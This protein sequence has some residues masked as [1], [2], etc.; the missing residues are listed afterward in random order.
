MDNMSDMDDDNLDTSWIQTETQLQNLQH[1][2][3]REPMENIHAVFLYINQNNYIDKIVRELIQLTPDGNSGSH[4]TPEML[5]KIIQTKKYC[6][7]VSKYK[8]TNMYTYIVDIEPDKIQSFSKTNHDELTNTMF[9]KE[10]PITGTIHVP[11][12]VF[13]FHSI[14]TVYFFFQELLVEKNDQPLKSILKPTRK[15][16]K[17]EPDNKPSGKHTKKVR[18][19]DKQAENREYKRHVRKRGTRKRRM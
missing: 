4:I 8:F 18:I 1:N 13:I 17:G 11:P 5:L 16:G 12:S 14:N 7:P 19:F 9:F 15:R 10:T 2:Y 3:V 6:T